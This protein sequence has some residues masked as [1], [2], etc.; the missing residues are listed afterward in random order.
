MTVVVRR[1][2]TLGRTGTYALRLGECLRYLAT[3]VVEERAQ[4]HQPMV[5]SSYPI[6]P[7]ILQVLQKAQYALGGEVGE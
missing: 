2:R 5:P 7:L 6:A 3:D 4:S 1:R